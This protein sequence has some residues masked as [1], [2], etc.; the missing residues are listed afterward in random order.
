MTIIVRRIIYIIFILIFLLAAPAILLYTTGYNYNFKRGGFIKTGV[1]LVDAL[2][3]DARVRLD[4]KLLNDKL[5][6][7][8]S[9]LKPKDY[10]IAIERDGYSSWQKTLT[11]DSGATV[12]ATNIFLPRQSSPDQLFSAQIT[13]ALFLEKGNQFIFVTPAKGGSTVLLFDAITK[14][15]QVL[16]EHLD[17]ATP[18]L[19]L[20][21]NEKYILVE[22]PKQSLSINL[23]KPGEPSILTGRHGLLVGMSFED[24]NDFVIYA[25]DGGM[26][27]RQNLVTNEKNDIYTVGN[28]NFLVN[29]GFLYWT[30]SIPDN[31]F[32][33]RRAS[34]FGNGEK[35]KTIFNPPRGNYDIQALNDTILLFERTTQTFTLLDTATWS[36]LDSGQLTGQLPPTQNS[37]LYWNASEIWIK[38]LKNNGTNLVTRIG[39]KIIKAME[40]KKEPYVLYATNGALSLIEEDNRNTKNIYRLNAPN[41]I[42]DFFLN[43]DKQIYIIGQD[44]LYT[45]A[46]Q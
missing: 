13:K 37:W 20:S 11:I 33:L 1:L 18:R 25:R 40:L 39:E 5:P 3:N 21:P 46:L 38:N 44:G 26:V 27:I 12:Y 34:I 15:S 8:L 23:S 7:R 36:E 24:G 10:L 32:A 42:L 45:L 43:N 29:S 16:V 35:P 6:A 2:P 31:D 14:H 17:S 22:T 9:N 30:A 4:G 41:N 19:V 28:S